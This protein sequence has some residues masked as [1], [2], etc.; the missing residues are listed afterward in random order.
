MSAL[1]SRR[2]F[3]DLKGKLG[4]AHCL[5]RSAGWRAPSRAVGARIDRTSIYSSIAISIYLSMC[6]LCGSPVWPSS[7][8]VGPL[9]GPPLCMGPLCV[10]PLWVGPPSRRVRVPCGIYS[11]NVSRSCTRSRIL[12]THLY[13]DPGL[14][15]YVYTYSIQL[16]CHRRTIQRQGAL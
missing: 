6:V 7:A 12:S 11:R 15:R 14:D 9:W 8:V 13:I 3:L 16:P 1:S 2:Q 4:P 5:R 10:G